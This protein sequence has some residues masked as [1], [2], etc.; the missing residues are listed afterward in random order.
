MKEIRYSIEKL[1]RN[2]KPKVN[3]NVSGCTLTYLSISIITM[4][5]CVKIVTEANCERNKRD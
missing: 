3:G 2:Y 5:Q 4:M 1:P